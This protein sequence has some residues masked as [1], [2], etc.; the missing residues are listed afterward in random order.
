MRFLSLNVIGY[1]MFWAFLLRE[2][3]QVKLQAHVCVDHIR[4]LCSTF[5]QAQCRLALV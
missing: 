4:N 5:T 1:V 3:P 2:K